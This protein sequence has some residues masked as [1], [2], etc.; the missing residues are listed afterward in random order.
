MFV[1][2]VD[3]WNL[4]LETLHPQKFDFFSN[5]RKK[6]LFS[7]SPIFYIYGDVSLALS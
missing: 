2:T 3:V 5:I 7:L 1:K 4:I 6:S